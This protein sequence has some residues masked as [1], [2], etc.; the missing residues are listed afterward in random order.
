MKSSGNVQIVG[1]SSLDEL[2]GKNVLV[3]DDIIDSGMTLSNLIATLKG[4]EV[5]K[6]WTAILLSKRVQ[7]RSAAQEDFIAFN[8]PDKFIVGYGLDYNQ[9]FRD[10]NHI[11]VM[12]KAGVEKYKQ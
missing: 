9:Q 10:L 3:V 8:I 7:R 1:M 4:L 6:I 2:K 5:S 12:S 11:A